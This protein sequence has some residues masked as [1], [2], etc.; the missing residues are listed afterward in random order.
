MAA[1][2]DVQGAAVRTAAE[3]SR[4]RM[5]LR[6]TVMSQPWGFSGTPVVGQVRSARSKASA[7][8]SSASAMS[9][10]EA[11]SNAT[12][13]PYDSRGGTLGGRAGVSG[14]GHLTG[15]APCHEPCT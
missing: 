1:M 4:S 9:P 10:V 5:R 6:A 12:S 14:S 13:R 2:S 7:S 8:A 3:A 15:C 11:A